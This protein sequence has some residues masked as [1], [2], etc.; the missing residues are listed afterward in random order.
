MPRGGMSQGRVVLVWTSARGCR[1]REAIAENGQGAAS[2][3]DLRFLRSLLF[4]NRR[5]QAGRMAT[6]NARGGR[7][8]LPR[9]EQ[10]DFEQKATKVT[11]G[12]TPSPMRDKERKGR[13]RLDWRTA[14]GL[15]WWGADY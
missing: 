1:S 10:E 5:P 13:V 8:D 4:Q 15:R 3:R 9:R 7:R 12:G 6:E 14:G 11:K 2:F